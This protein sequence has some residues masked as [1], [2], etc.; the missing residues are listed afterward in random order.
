M[1]GGR[2]TIWAQMENGAPSHKTRHRA[3][4]LLG[5]TGAGKT[6]LGEIIERR[7]LR[8]MRCLHFDFGANLREVVARDRP[9]ALITR[10]DIAFLN[11]VLQSGAL[12]EN[13]GFPIALRI[14]SSFLARRQADEDTCVVLNGLPR[15][16]GQA[17]AMEA[18]LD[19]RLVIHLQ[20]STET[21]ISRI[22]SNIGGDRA[23]RVDDD[24][25]AIRNKLQIYHSRTAP[26]LEHYRRRDVRI[27]T[28]EVTAHATAEQIWQQLQGPPNASESSD[29]A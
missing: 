29:G 10:Q 12:L 18:V 20:C 15:H 23:D 16:V 25:G 19:V 1:R 3:I 21:V 17:R 4:V 7:G 5:P 11:D 26:L 6:P 13:E 22:S 2:R 9:D 14:L 24:L 28:V 8:G 27:E